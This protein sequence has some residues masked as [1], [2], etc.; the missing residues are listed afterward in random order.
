MKK[1][2]IIAYVIILLIVIFIIKG[3]DINK[4]GLMEDQ[5]SFYEDSLRVSRDSEGTE[6]AKVNVLTISNKSLIKDL[7]SF[8][9]LNNKLREEISKKSVSGVYISSSTSASI[10]TKTDTFYSNCDTLPVYESSYKDKW[11]SY[12]IVAGKDSINLYQLTVLNQYVGMFKEKGGF[13]KKKSIEFAFKSYN[14]YTTTEEM[15]AFS[16]FPK[17]KKIGL[18]LN[19]GYGLTSTGLSPYVGIGLNY[20]L[21]RF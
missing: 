12:I 7:K 4:L 14:P 1:N 19:V 15:Q 17:P 18:G 10:V 6:T 5:I 11:L 3:C 16:H 20:N 9:G 8:K 2:H 13:L 21:I